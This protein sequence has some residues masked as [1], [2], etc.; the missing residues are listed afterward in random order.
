ME[1]CGCPAFIPAGFLMKRHKSGRMEIF[2]ENSK[3]F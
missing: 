2:Y 3:I 1:I